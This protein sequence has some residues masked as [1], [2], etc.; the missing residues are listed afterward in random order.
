MDRRFRERAPRVVAGTELPQI[1]A[2]A[3]VPMSADAANSDF[4][5]IDGLVPVDFIDT[6]TTMANEKATGAPI[7]GR[8]HNRA[9]EAR[10][11]ATDPRARLADQDLDNLRAE[12]VYPNYAMY[13]FGG[14]GPGVSA[15]MLSAFITTGWR[16]TARS[17]PPVC[18]V[19][20]RCRWA[21]RSMG[22][23]RKRSARPSS[24]SNRSC[25]RPTL[26]IVRGGDPYY[27]PLW[28]ALSDWQL[29]VGIP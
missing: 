17:L 16:N 8:D 4:F 2:Y 22:Q 29:P 18:W 3:H 6:I 20:V 9:S 25:C 5:L 26:P 12:V 7:K 27:I 24:V 15:R 14:A 21:D 19:S 28:E 1:A 10:V 23:W 13:M 11:G